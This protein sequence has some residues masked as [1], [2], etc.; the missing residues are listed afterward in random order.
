MKNIKRNGVKKRE[1]T[2]IAKQVIP[3]VSIRWT[4]YKF[5]KRHYNV[6][7]YDQATKKELTVSVQIPRHYYDVANLTLGEKS[8]LSLKTPNNK[9]IARL[10]G[11]AY[12]SVDVIL[13]KN[14]EHNLELASKLSIALK[15]KDYSANIMYSGTY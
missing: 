9:R 7:E 2:S 6:K 11:I 14:S 1:L 13:Y 10:E 12:N 4:S 8:I 5:P 3:E 15:E